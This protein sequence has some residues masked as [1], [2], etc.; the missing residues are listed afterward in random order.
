MDLREESMVLH[1][2]YNGKIETRAKVTLE[3]DHDLAIAYT[4][5]V[6]QPCLAIKADPDRSFDLTCRG[7]MVAI[8]TDGTRVLGLGNI[9]AR[10]AMP[11]MEGKAALFRRFGAVDAV[12]VCI[13]EPDKDKFIA[14]VKSLQANYAGIN[15]EDIQSPKCYD[16]EDELKKEL[17][18]PVFH[19][20]QHG[21][22][23]A[24]VSAVMGALRLV[25]KD[26]RTAKIVLNGGG[27][28]GTAIG[29]LLVDCGAENLTVMLHHGT[30]CEG[31]DNNGRPLDRVQEA[32]SKVTNREKRL[33]S[34][35][36]IVKGADVLLGVSAAGAF[37]Q[38]MI[39][40]MAPDAVV[41]AMANPV[42]EISYADAKAAGARVAGTGRSDTPNQVNNVNVFPGVFRGAIDVR[43]REI[44]E[45]MKV[46]AVRAIAELIPE[47]ELREDY[48][49]PNAFDKRVAPA[50]A[51]AVAR[52][53]VETGVARAPKDPEVVL[54]ETYLRV[55]GVPM[56]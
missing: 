5:G 1:E 17:E 35:A 44:N 40:S 15:L 36:D 10:A 18:I 37:T 16:I 50:V 55:N 12:P 32:L 24:C 20:D 14:I 43:A 9:G 33:G 13:D 52:A 2:K 26:I 6:A 8:C 39:R 19:D 48:V 34:L 30:L 49:V 29:R 25:K 23:I 11:V 53:A 54:R 7:N 22:A 56:D 46:A 4:P 45:A 42:P 31:H 38:E 41:F 3:N 28:A 27:A 21:T 47:E 51:A